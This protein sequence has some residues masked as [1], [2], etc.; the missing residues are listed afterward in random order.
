METLPRKKEME[1]SSWH[2]LQVSTLTSP[3]RVMLRPLHK[4]MKTMLH[5][6]SHVSQLALR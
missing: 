5:K 4:K 2:I 6:K 3:D 1:P